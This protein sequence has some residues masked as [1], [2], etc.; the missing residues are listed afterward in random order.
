MRQITKEFTAM[1]NTRPALDDRIN[2]FM[3]GWNKENLGHLEIAS[4]HT[5]EKIFPGDGKPGSW[6]VVVFDMHPAT[7]EELRMI[8][9]QRIYDR[10]VNNE[11]RVKR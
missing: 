1:S 6:V 9:A 11:F 3:D 2:D 4:M 7:P 5:I 8:E 10:N